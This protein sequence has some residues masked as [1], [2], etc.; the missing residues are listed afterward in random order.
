MKESVKQQQQQ[1]QQQQ[2]LTLKEA[3]YAFRAS[4]IEDV[5]KQ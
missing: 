5:G 3:S 4:A 1:Q 2:R